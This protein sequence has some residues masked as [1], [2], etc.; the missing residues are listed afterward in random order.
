M[1]E[2]IFKDMAKRFQDM[3]KATGKF[4][5]SLAKV[6]LSMPIPMNYETWVFLHK[7]KDSNDYINEERFEFYLN[8]NGQIDIIDKIESREKNAICIYNDLGVYPYSSAKAICDLLNE[9][10][11]EIKRLKCINR[12]LEE[13]LDKSIALDMSQCGDVE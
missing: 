5:Q 1:T 8:S 3:G 2:N 4:N 11:K 9:Q 12:Q 7:I 10:D 6:F 13:R